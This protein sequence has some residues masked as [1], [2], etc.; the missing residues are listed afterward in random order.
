MASKMTFHERFGD[1]TVA[2]LR[3]YKKFN[4]SQSDHD[5]LADHFGHAAHDE[6]T[7]YVKAHSESGMY[8]KAHW[9]RF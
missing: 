4:V 3:A 2:Q 8:Q 9:N 5:E 6:I 7:A 1:V